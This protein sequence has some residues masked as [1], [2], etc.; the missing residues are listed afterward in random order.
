MEPLSGNVSALPQYSNDPLKKNSLQIYN[1]IHQW[2]KL[3]FGKQQTYGD[4]LNTNVIAE[5]AILLFQKLASSFNDSKYLRP[6]AY[7]TMDVAARSYKL[8]LKEGPLEKTSLFL[9]YH[10]ID[11]IPAAENYL[12]ERMYGKL[13][14]FSKNLPVSP[15]AELITNPPTKDPLELLSLSM[16]SSHVIIGCAYKVGQHKTI[17]IHVSNLAVSLKKIFKPENELQFIELAKKSLQNLQSEFH[18]QVSGDFKHSQFINSQAAPGEAPPAKVPEAEYNP[19][20]PLP[21]LQ[22]K[23]S[24]E[25]KKGVELLFLYFQEARKSE[26]TPYYLTAAKEEA[27]FSIYNTNFSMGTSIKQDSPVHQAVLFGLS[28]SSF[29]G[30]HPSPVTVHPRFG[31]FKEFLKTFKLDCPEDYL[32]ERWYGTAMTLW[33]IAHKKPIV[34]YINDIVKEL[35]PKTNAKDLLLDCGHVAGRMSHTITMYFPPSRPYVQ[36]EDELI[37]HA[38]FYAVEKIL[39]GGHPFPLT[40]P[41]SVEILEERSMEI[42]VAF[43][44]KSTSDII[45]N[46]P[47]PLKEFTVLLLKAMNEI[48][49]L[50]TTGRLEKI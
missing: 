4:F 50:E 45:F 26:N 9:T 32:F 36:K 38:C 21:R 35:Y 49:G 12:Y 20:N 47:I 22:T 48:S 5:R 25:Y 16:L 3:T 2:R 31:V 30:E 17:A 15:T 7:A 24:P 39:T 41:F 18:H 13:F 10:S 11:P 29:S 37:G 14:F 33:K 19:A 27:V 23:L 6:L 34:A 8:P 43:F 28:L 44:G 46:S 40:S 1:C 42:M